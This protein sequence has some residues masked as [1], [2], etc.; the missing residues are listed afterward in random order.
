MTNDL[1]CFFHG[2]PGAGECDGQLIRAHLIPRQVLR[3]EARALVVREARAAGKPAGLAVTLMEP[4]VAR[5]IED[6]R[7][8]VPCC[9]GPTGIGGHH[10]QLDHSRTL[11]IPFDAL[12]YGFIEFCEELG[13]GWYIT[14]TYPKEANLS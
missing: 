2:W 5:L 7:S 9:G 4:Y 12:P 3:R 10:G 11:R 6:P 14:R 1:Q 13:L 8:W